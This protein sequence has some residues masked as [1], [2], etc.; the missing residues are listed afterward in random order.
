MQSRY[1]IQIKLFNSCWKLSL[2][3]ADDH[4][5]GSSYYVKQP[6]F[7]AERLRSYGY[8]TIVPRPGITR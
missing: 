4:I 6:A 7:Y 1:L 3:R 5:N 2:Q 8:G